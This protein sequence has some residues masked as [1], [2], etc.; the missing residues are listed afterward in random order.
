V[1]PFVDNHPNARGHR[2]LS[3]F[4]GRTLD[5]LGLLGPRT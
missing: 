4:V 3:Y 1:L 5:E 2:R